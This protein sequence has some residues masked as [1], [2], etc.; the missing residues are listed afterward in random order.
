MRKAKNALEK[1]AGEQR[2]LCT[3]ERKGGLGAE[4]GEEGEKWVERYLEG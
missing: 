4:K 1:G 2:S 3:L